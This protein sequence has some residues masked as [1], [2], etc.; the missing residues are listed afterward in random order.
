MI[1]ALA[2][3]RAFASRAAAMTKRCVSLARGA[4]FTSG[5]PAAGGDAR[6]ELA[7]SAAAGYVGNSNHAHI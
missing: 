1:S 2:G 6:R 7:G 5:T 3:R 4:S